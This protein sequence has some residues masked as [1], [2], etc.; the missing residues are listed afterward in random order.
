MK[1]I[2]E[3]CDIHAGRPVDSHNRAERY[4]IGY[5]PR[6]N[7]ENGNLNLVSMRDG[8]QITQEHTEVSL[9]AYLNGKEGVYGGYRPV[10]VC[11]D[12]IPAPREEQQADSRPEGVKP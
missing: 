10:E 4:V 6:R 1:Y 8:M 2:W 3:A 9:A 11:Q 7:H 12:D 5:D